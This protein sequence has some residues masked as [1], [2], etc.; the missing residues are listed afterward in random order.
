MHHGHPHRGQ[1]RVVDSP[2]TGIA[3]CAA[4]GVLGTESISAAAEPSLKGHRCWDYNTLKETPWN[5]EASFDENI[6]FFTPSYI[7]PRKALG[8]N[9]IL[10][11][12]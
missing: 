11:Y 5:L 10:V 7:G 9:S 8:N 4:M 2:G 3:V 12:A 6:C 1:K